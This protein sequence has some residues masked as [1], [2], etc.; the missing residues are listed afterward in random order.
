MSPSWSITGSNAAP[1]FDHRGHGA[2]LAQSAC[3]G[4]Q[5]K[6]NVRDD[7][8]AGSLDMVEYL[9]NQSSK[10]PSTPISLARS[11][12]SPKAPVLRPGRH[13][14]ADGRAWAD[15]SAQA[16]SPPAPGGAQPSE[17]NSIS[18][19]SC[20]RGNQRVLLPAP[21]GAAAVPGEPACVDRDLGCVA[22]VAADRQPEGSG[23][24]GI[25]DGGRAGRDRDD[26]GQQTR[27]RYAILYDDYSGPAATRL[28]AFADHQFGHNNVDRPADG[29]DQI[30]HRGRGLA[31]KNED[32]QADHGLRASPQDQRI[33][34]QHPSPM[35]GD[36]ALADGA[37]G[38]RQAGDDAEAYDQTGGSSRVAEN[39][40]SATITRPVTAMVSPHHQHRTEAAVG[41]A[42]ARYRDV[43]AV[44]TTEIAPTLLL[45]RQ[46][47]RIAGLRVPTL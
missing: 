7:Q 23:Q 14:Q 2:T 30:H 1:D 15:Q 13:P 38:Q 37:D 42:E 11:L 26:H 29:Q 5:I 18:L 47:A 20:R 34:P 19:H 32:R 24:E 17:A 27:R 4:R 44:I 22:C 21:F 10:H 35:L 25:A 31:V 8:L 6:L 41:R 43:V 33:G 9:S 12:A 3:K 16:F 45:R 39:E 46:M 28:P 40:C 36:V